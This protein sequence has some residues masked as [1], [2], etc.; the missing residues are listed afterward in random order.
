VAQVS[1]LDGIRPRLQ[2]MRGPL[3]APPD[4]SIVIPVNAKADLE[5]VL[6]TLTDLSR[7]EGLAALE[8]VLVV[9]NFPAD[10]EP[11]EVQR[12][13]DLGA[14]VVAVPSVRRSGEAVALSARMRGLRVAVADFAIFFDADCRMPQVTELLDWYVAQF[15]AGVQV[16]YTRVGYF[17]THPGAPVRAWLL[18]H[19]LSRWIKRVVFRIPT[20]QGASYGVDRLAALRLYDSGYLADEMNVGPSIKAQGG[21]TSYSGS[22][23]V[24]ASGRYLTF[25]TWRK[26]VRYFWYRLKYNIRVLPV[27][28]DSATRTHRD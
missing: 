3:D 10:S 20:T 26:V 14:V 18:G 1:E 4:A 11:I 9:N 16:A 7:Y 27:R 15:R 25:F 6:V 23:Q 5:N 19:A 8:I 21:R 17:D 12:L 28:S 24:L 22:L 2:R 13:R